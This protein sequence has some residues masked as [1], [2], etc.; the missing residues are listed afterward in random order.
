MGACDNYHFHKDCKHYGKC[1]EETVFKGKRKYIRFTCPC[2]KYPQLYYPN[3]L[4][5]IKWECGLFEPK[6]ED[7]KEIIKQ[8]IKVG[9]GEEI[10]V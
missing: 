8:R 5:T 2:L 9:K 7:L 1:K 3:D 10:I 6:Q 4:H